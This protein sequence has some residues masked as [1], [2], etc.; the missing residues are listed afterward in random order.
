M[1]GCVVRARRHVEQVVAESGKELG[2][3]VADR[4]VPTRTDDPES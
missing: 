3:R 2:V 4:L 1:T